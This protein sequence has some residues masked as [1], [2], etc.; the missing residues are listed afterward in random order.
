MEIASIAGFFLNFIILYLKGHTDKVWTISWSPI[1]LTL[2]SSG[3]DKS[4][5]IWSQTKNI[6]SNC[7]HQQSLI[8][9]AHTRT[10][11]SVAF[12]PSG[13]TLASCSFDSNTILWTRNTSHG[14]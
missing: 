10:I 3:T 6:K 12:S 8:T 5:R 4:I 14:K 1:D 11:R 9:D 2:V 7:W 13:Q